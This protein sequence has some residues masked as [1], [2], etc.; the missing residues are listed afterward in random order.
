MLLQEQ[1]GCTGGRG[2]SATD[3]MVPLNLDEDEHEEWEASMMKML[4]GLGR[5][6]VTTGRSDH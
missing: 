4:E 3:S 2:V 5:E 1:P 6:Q